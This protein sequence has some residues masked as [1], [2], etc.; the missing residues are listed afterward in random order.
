MNVYAGFKY[1]T[2]SGFQT[3]RT[4]IAVPDAFTVRRP[5]R[6]MPTQRRIV[7]EASISFESAPVEAVIAGGALV[8][9]T[10]GYLIFEA[11]RASRALGDAASTSG[12]TT[13][14]TETLPRKDAVV[15]FGASGRTGRQIVA[16]LLRKGR[17]VI[18][19][20][21]DEDRTREIFSSLGCIQ[22][23]QSSGPGILFIQRGVDVTRPETL[24]VELFQGAQQVICALG[25]VFGRLSDG[26]M[27]YLDGMTSERVDAEGV[28]N[29]AAAAAVHLPR[30][31]RVLADVLPMSSEED[32][33]K[34]QR[35]DDVIMGGNSSSVLERARDGSDVAVWRGDL[36][37]E[38]GGFCGTR[39]L[40]LQL[41]LSEYDGIALRVRGRGRALKLNIK[42]DTFSEPEDTYQA[43]FD[44]A[45]GEDWTSVF[46]PWH[47]FIPVKRA[48][49][50]PS[51]PPLDPSKIR[52]FG[53]VYSRFA[54]NGFPNDAHTPGPFEIEFEGG[55]RAY[56]APRPQLV[57]MSS[58]GV[59]R[60][61]RIGDDEAARKADIPIVQLNPGGVLNHKYTGEAAV[62]ASGLTYLVVRPTGMSDDAAEAGPALLELSQGDRI[63]GKIARGEVAS[64]IA[65]ALGL[66]AAV[67]KTVEVRRSEAV[68]AQ[69]RV[70]SERNLLG[71]F[72]TAVNDRYRAK[73]GIEPFPAPVP[74][75]PT[76][77]EQRKAEILA[78]P[79]VQQARA[80][81]AGGR[82]RD[83]EESSRAKTI[84]KADDGRADV[85]G[86]PA[87]NGGEHVE[88]RGAAART[89]QVVPDNV[90]EAKEWIRKWRA[91]NLERQLP[92]GAATAVRGKDD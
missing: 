45:D 83:E 53:L 13:R 90:S 49:T 59:E 76:P 61:A 6:A 41:D 78:D 33:A 39:T 14:T 68:D 1:R 29:V 38:G 40:P 32:L 86:K 36:V 91:N 44:T 50:V 9:A 64:L 25:P 23:R 28:S 18:A 47:E 10:S 24:T 70:P 79:R 72:L 17:T 63:S 8:L 43:A 2:A 12:E 77:T 62:R 35:L 52:S 22:G 16:E 88:D 7:T 5:R 89:P 67:G 15:V 27:G 54:F 87:S 57:L 20:V 56:K 82:V 73:A 55:I 46:I 26:S 75:P 11:L 71:S 80:R 58:A 92:G 30:T 42:T 48:K 19:A 37:I 74:P 60:N 81:N 3:N 65:T 34:W 51:G 66:P 4:A 31:A 85:S 21:R 84:V 69:G